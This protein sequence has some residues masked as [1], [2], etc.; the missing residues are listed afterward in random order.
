MRCLP[1]R[2][3]KDS[4][5][6][7]SRL[8]QNPITVRLPV[9]SLPSNDHS[10][11]SIFGS[12]RHGTKDWTVKAHAQAFLRQVGLDQRLQSFPCI[13]SLLGICQPRLLE[14]RAKEGLRSNVRCFSWEERTTA[15]DLCY[16]N[17]SLA[18]SVRVAQ[19]LIAR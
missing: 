6:G 19:Q 10:V 9:L 15:L 5:L 14:A 4:F 7:D 3:S 1:W 18:G 8:C 12:S 2:L 17:G 16:T 13:R 11:R